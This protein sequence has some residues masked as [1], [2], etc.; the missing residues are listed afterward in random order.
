VLDADGATIAALRRDG[1]GVHTLDSAHDKAYT[2]VSFRNN[3]LALAGRAKPFC[4]IEVLGSST[5]RRA[6]KTTEFVL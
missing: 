3:T 2:A 4:Q 6:R 1:A 5:T